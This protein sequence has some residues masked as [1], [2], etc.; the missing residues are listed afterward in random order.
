[1]KNF[2]FSAIRRMREVLS[3]LG[4]MFALS[5]IAACSSDSD[6]GNNNG[7]GKPGF[8]DDTTWTIHYQLPEGDIEGCPNWKEAN[9]FDFENTMTAIICFDSAMSSLISNEDRIAVIIDGE[10]RDIA[11]IVNYKEGEPVFMMLVPFEADDDKVELQYYNAK[12]NQTYIIADAFSVWDDTVGSEDSNLFYICLTPKVNIVITMPDN[13]PFLHEPDD[14]M[15]IFC[16]DECCG[17]PV[18]SDRKT[19]V[20]TVYK[21]PQLTGTKAHVRYYSAEKQAIYTTDDIIDLSVSDTTYA[22]TFK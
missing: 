16:G 21:L 20:S 5:L 2:N 12:K 13:L 18:A 22:I 14:K 10:A 17:L 9:F 19:W 7:N 6:N 1:M 4:I 15:G 11:N 3:M 8:I